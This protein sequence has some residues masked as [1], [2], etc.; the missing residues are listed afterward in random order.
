MNFY[1]DVTAAMERKGKHINEMR[2]RV[3]AFRDYLADGDSAMMT[4]DF[5]GCLNSRRILKGV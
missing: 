2:I 3:I 5:F 1:H 4:T